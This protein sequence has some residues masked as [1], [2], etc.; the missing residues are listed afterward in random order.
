MPIIRSGSVGPGA[1]LQKL[2]DGNAEIVATVICGDT[3]F[4]ENTE[5]AINKILKLVK[6]YEFNG[7]VAGPA[8]NAGRY[9]I[10][11]GAVCKA[12]KDK[13]ESQY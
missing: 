10:A 6:D 11:C 3:Y 13:F 4:A 1:A 8:F 7:F 5:E 2:L 9:G 12:I